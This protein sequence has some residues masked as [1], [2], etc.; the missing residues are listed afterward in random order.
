MAG[1]ALAKGARVGGRKAVYGGRRTLCAGQKR[2]PACQRE[3][4][5]EEKAGSLVAQVASHAAQRSTTGSAVVTHRRRTERSG[6]RFS[7]P[8]PA[9]PQQRPSGDAPQLSVSRRPT[10][11]PGG[12]AAGWPLFAPF[13]PRGRGSRG[14]LGALYTTGTNRGGL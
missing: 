11:A 10:T 3:S 8:A 13:E 5:A 1:S 9:T 2:R 4:H 7:F 6:Q 14:A 12:G